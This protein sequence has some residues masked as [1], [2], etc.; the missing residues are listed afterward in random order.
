MFCIPYFRLLVCSV[1]LISVY[2]YVLYTIFQFSSMFCIPY[3]SLL[4][5]SVYHISVYQYVLYTIQLTSMFC[6]SY[7]S[8]QYVLYTIFQFTSMFSILY[9]SLLVCSVYHISVYQY[10]LYT[11]QLTSIFCIPYFSLLVCSVYHEIGHAVS[12][13]SEDVRVL[14]FGVFILFILPAAY[15]DLPTDQLRNKTSLQRLRDG[16]LIWKSFRSLYENM[17]KNQFAKNMSSCHIRKFS[18][19]YIFAT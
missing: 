11:I 8:L 18:Y 4:V 3:F 14:G 19:H 7:F 6:I 17:K 16:V 12:A 1:Y 10:V 5:C 15:V 9:F 13:V 2:Q